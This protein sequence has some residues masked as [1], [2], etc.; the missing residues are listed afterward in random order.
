[1]LPL[2]SSSLAVDDN[3]ARGVVRRALVLSNGALGA[4]GQ[5]LGLVRA[6]GLQSRFQTVHNLFLGGPARPKNPMRHRQPLNCFEL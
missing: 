4:E 2:A 1:M 5:C 6:L 3:S